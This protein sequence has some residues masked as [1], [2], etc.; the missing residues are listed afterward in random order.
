LA[1][2]VKTLKGDNNK[3]PNKIVYFTLSLNECL[4]LL[5]FYFLFVFS[6]IIS[7]HLYVIFLI[8][9]NNKDFYT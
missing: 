5:L 1:L 4:F 7:Y 9:N 6:Y 8:K 3:K 2:N